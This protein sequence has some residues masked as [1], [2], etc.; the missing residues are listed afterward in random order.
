MVRVGSGGGKMVEATQI[1]SKDT[2]PLNGMN[3]NTGRNE[4]PFASR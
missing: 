2:A 1:H 4:N 3:F